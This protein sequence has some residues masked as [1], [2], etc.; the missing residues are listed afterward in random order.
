VNRV[1]VQ[2]GTTRLRVAIA[3]PRPRLLAELPVSEAG[4][5]LAGYTALLDRPADELLVVHGL[6]EPPVVPAT[7]PPSCGSFP[8]RSLRSDP[9]TARRSATPIARDPTPWSSTAG[10]AAPTW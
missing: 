2:L 7:Q 9:S 4:P 10:T 6:G 1:A 3:D 5:D 8:R